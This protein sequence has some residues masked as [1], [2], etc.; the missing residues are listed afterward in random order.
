MN[1][2]TPPLILI[3]M[4]LLPYPA[5]SNDDRNDDE[6]RTFDFNGHLSGEQEVTPPSAPSTPSLGVSTDTSGTILVRVSSDL[7]SLQFRLVVR[8]GADVTQ[9][10]LHCGRAGQNGPVVVF[11]APLTEQGRD[12]DGLLAQGT[13]RNEKYARNSSRGTAM[14]RRRVTTT[15]HEASMV[16]LAALS[17]SLTRG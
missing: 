5:L 14:V 6:R 11:L 3:S 12:V 9:A 8:D 4:F 13:R 1:T 10:H 7:S 17:A 16:S 15:E 2:R